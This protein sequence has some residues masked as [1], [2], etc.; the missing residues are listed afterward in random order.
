MNVAKHRKEVSRMPLI[1]STHVGPSFVMSPSISSHVSQ[2][3][4]PLLCH[5]MRI[6]VCIAVDILGSFWPQTSASVTILLAVW[7]VLPGQP[8]AVAFQNATCRIAPLDVAV[9]L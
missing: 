8:L 3:S 1:A 5:A 6:C 7:S 4:G 2:P 9:V